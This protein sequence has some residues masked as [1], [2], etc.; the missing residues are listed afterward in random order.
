M[1]FAYSPLY[2]FIRSITSSKDATAFSAAWKYWQIEAF[3]LSVSDKV[4]FLSR[5]SFGYNAED[6]VFMC[7]VR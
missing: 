7:R 2:Y 1:R 3:Y 6:Q 5:V 4:C